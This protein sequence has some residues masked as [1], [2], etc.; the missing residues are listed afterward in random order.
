MAAVS[1]CLPWWDFH[2]IMKT[3]HKRTDTSN[4][5]FTLCLNHLFGGSKKRNLQSVQ[6]L[7]FFYWALFVIRRFSDFFL[8]KFFRLIS[9]WS[10]LK[11]VSLFQHQNFA[12]GDL[13]NFALR[14]WAVQFQRLF[15]FDF[16]PFFSIKI[17]EREDLIKKSSI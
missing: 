11:Q 6:L 12:V 3:L 1:K 8:M 2:L 4:E 10:P 14:V 13:I 5:L 17:Q 15:L 9:S 16:L 7:V